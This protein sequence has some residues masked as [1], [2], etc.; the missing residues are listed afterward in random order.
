MSPFWWFSAAK[1]LW[2]SDGHESLG[3]RLTPNQ[4]QDA[5]SR[6]LR[7]RV[8]PGDHDVPSRAVLQR[9]HRLHAAHRAIPERRD[10]RA[11]QRT[12]PHRQPVFC[13]F[14]TAH[15]LEVQQDTACRLQGGVSRGS[16]RRDGGQHPGGQRRELQRRAEERHGRHEE[17]G[18]Q[19]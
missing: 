7:E 14:C 11:P 6:R 1:G 10:G 16:G 12:G 5:S 13:V 18:G 15:P 4:F 9:R 2:S 8:L 3:D 17:P 19:I